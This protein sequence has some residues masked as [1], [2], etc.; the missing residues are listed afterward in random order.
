MRSYGVTNAAPYSAAPAIGLAGDLYWNIAEKALYGSDGVAWNKVGASAANGLPTGGTAGAFLA[1]LSSVD[2]AAQ[3]DPNRYWSIGGSNTT[4]TPTDATKALAVPGPTAAGV[5]QSAMRLGSRTQKLRVWALPAFDWSGLTL[6]NIYDGSTWTRDDTA[7][8]A[9]RMLMR[10]DSLDQFAVERISATNVGTQP[11]SIDG[12]A[13]AT[14]GRVNVSIPT[15]NTSCDVFTGKYG[16][17]AAR[18]HFVVT[19]TGAA[20][21]YSNVGWGSGPPDDTAQPSWAMTIGWGAAADG[22]RVS[23]AP[24]TTGAPA[25]VPLLDLT[26]TG[27]MICAYG[28]FVRAGGANSTGWSQ[29]VRGDTTNPGYLAIYHP[30]ATRVAY[31]G[32]ASGTKTIWQSDAANWGLALGTQ[33]GAFDFYGTDTNIT[34]RGT[35]RSA[36]WFRNGVMTFYSDVDGIHRAWGNAWGDWWQCYNQNPGYINFAAETCNKRAHRQRFTTHVSGTYYLDSSHEGVIGNCDSG[37]V[38]FYLPIA[39]GCQGRMYYVT[40]WRGDGSTAAG[41]Y[42]TIACQGSDTIEGNTQIQLQQQYAKTVL[43]AANYGYAWFR[44]M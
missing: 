19:P 10:T 34:M 13:G 25:W 17:V 35:N 2:Y 27:A 6:N 33:N 32:W 23:R 31:L 21:L 40:R 3:W 11:L 28:D 4:L 18:A 8:P 14:E 42:V 30:N 43:F 1:K 39:S 7:K 24:A 22:Y 38:L 15:T 36:V 20:G 37:A 9:W 44:V 26:N 12:G 29:I 5:D 16:T 41:T